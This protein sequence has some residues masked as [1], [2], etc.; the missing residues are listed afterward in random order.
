MRAF[1]DPFKVDCFQSIDNAAA[2][3]A[4]KPALRDLWPAARLPHAG[5]PE[6][7]A[8]SEHGVGGN[9]HS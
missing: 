2:R 9:V 6:N 3:K 1:S 4:I 7:H 8:A 5:V